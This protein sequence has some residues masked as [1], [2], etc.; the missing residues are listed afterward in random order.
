MDGLLNAL[1]FAH[2]MSVYIINSAFS[3]GEIVRKMRKLQFYRFLQLFVSRG[4]P[5]YVLVA[6]R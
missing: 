3:S 1:K 2:K 6:K 4:R 5:V